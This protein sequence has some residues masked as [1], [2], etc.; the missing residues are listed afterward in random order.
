[1]ESEITYEYEG[2]EKAEITF[3]LYMK[4]ENYSGAQRVEKVTMIADKLEG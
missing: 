2:A 1:M 4:R 3:E